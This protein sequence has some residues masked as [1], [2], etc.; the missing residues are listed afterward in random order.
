M[1]TGRLD[2]LIGNGAVA[3]FNMNFATL[4]ANGLIT[5]SDGT[6]FQVTVGGYTPPGLEDN[7]T[8]GAHIAFTAVPEPTSMVM[9]GMGW[10]GERVRPVP[11]PEDEG[12]RLI[13]ASPTR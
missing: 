2:G 7:G 6:H 3:L 13:E 11:P 8:L 1:F 12:V 4:P 9:L 5:A 10:R